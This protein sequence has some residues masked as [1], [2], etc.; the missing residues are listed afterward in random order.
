MDRELGAPESLQYL[1]RL[2]CEPSAA[3]FDSAFS[4]H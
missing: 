4:S 2:N 3:S 1:K